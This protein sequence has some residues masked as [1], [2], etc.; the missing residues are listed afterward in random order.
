MHS[1]GVLFFDYTH[2]PVIVSPSW[3]QPK[4]E[5]QDLPHLPVDFLA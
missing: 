3:S 4:M 5:I 1:N 2:L